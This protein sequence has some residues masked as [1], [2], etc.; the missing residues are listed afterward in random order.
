MDAFQSSIL[1]KKYIIG[2]RGEALHNEFMEWIYAGGKVY[3]GLIKRR[4]Y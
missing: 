3:Q 4:Y 1:L 2:E